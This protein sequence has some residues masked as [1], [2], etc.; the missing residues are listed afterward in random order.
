MNKPVAILS[1]RSVL[2]IASIGAGLVAARGLVAQAAS[3][4][5]SGGPTV[6]EVL[7][8][9]SPGTSDS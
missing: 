2:R 8:S 3:P 4:P 1:R 6:D 9:S 7:H 5:G